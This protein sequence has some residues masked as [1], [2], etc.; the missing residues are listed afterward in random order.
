M[1]KSTMAHQLAAR[2]GCTSIV[3]PWDSI[4]MPL[5]PGALHLTNRVI[6]EA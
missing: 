4:G 3:D 1:G 6:A 2:L 5:I